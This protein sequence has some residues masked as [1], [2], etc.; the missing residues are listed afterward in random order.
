MREGKE[1]TMMEKKGWG[2]WSEERRLWTVFLGGCFLLGLLFIYRT[3]LGFNTA[4]EMYF[5]GTT[6]RLFQGDRLLIDEWHPSQQLSSFFIYPLYHILRLLLGS[7]EGIVLWIRLCALLLHLF[8][9]IIAFGRLKQKGWSAVMAVLLFFIFVPCGLTALSY[10]SLQ[11]T[12]FFLLLA[13]LYGKDSHKYYEYFLYGVLTAMVV[14]ANPFAILL[15]AGYGGIC[16]I[17]FF[18]SKKCGKPVTEILRLRSFFLITLGAVTVAILFA[19]F[20]LN[21]GSIQEVVKNLPYIL[22]NPDHQ[23]G[24]ASYWKKTKR[25]FRLIY[26]NYKYL[27]QIFGVLYPVILLDKKRWRHRAVYLG[28]GGICMAAYLIYYGFVYEHIPVNYQILPLVFL[29]LEAYMLTQKRD[30]RLFFCWYL[31]ALFY[32]MVVQYA[33]NTGIVMVSSAYG[34]STFASVILIGDLCKEIR[35]QGCWDSGKKVL[36]IFLLS[37]LCIQCAGTLYLRMSFALADDKTWRLNAHMDRGPL[38]GIYTSED[39][40]REYEQVLKELDTLSLTKEDQ[41]LVV[42]IAPWIYLYAEAGCGSYSTWQVDENTTQLSAYYELHPD[43][44][45]TVI[46]MMHWGE[47]FMK[48]PLAQPFW[49]R[50]YVVTQ[51]ERGIVMEAPDRRE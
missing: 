11:F 48:S 16:F 33:T 27:V 2:A 19:I 13:C 8:A 34:I 41:L 29:G 31:P 22:E 32:T 44:F 35:W 47:D 39:Q 51:M 1:R 24:M 40:A 42:G 26:S 37:V 50:G 5:V 6:E 28:T 45:P 14:L 36:F 30:R 38:K 17:V 12:G 4:D 25:Y 43:K 10:N 20:V 23:Q 18:W 9:A 46:Y 49:E 21:R 3:F 15:Y 7:T